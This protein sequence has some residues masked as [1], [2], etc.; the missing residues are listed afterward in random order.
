MT[1]SFSSG[2]PNFVP[3]VATRAAHAIETSRPPP[4][5]KFDIAATHG[6]LPFSTKRVKISLKSLTFSV[7]SPL[8]VFPKCAISNPPLNMPFSPRKT[9]AS[10]A[11]SSC[12]DWTFS[13]NERRRDSASAFTGGFFRVIIATFWFSVPRTTST[14]VVIVLLRRWWHAWESSVKSA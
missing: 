11:S 1:P 5:A 10:I 12:A 4:K 9:I 2:N 7:F 3:L 13:R 8:V 14:V 6:F